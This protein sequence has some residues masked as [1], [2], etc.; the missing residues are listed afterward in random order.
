MQKIPIGQIPLIVDIETGDTV[1]RPVYWTGVRKDFFSP[2]ENFYEKYSPEEIEHR[3][4]VKFPCTRQELPNDDLW[5]ITYNKG[6]R[7]IHQ[8]FLPGYFEVRDYREWI[9]K[10]QKFIFPIRIEF[11][12][13]LLY[14]EEI[15][16]PE[17]LIKAIQE[18]LAVIV[19]ES[20]WE[21]RNLGDWLYNPL[22]RFKSQYSIPDEQIFLCGSQAGDR[23]KISC[24]VP[25]RET[26]YFQEF[27]W[28]VQRRPITDPG[29][30]EKLQKW[31]TEFLS[32]TG[33]DKFTKTF[34]AEIGRSTYE[35]LFLFGDLHEE[36][37]EKSY[38]SFRNHYD[39]DI[40]TIKRDLIALRSHMSLHNTGWYD[41]VADFL[42]T[43][44]F[45]KRYEL[46]LDQ[47]EYPD[48]F[49]LESDKQF[50]KQSFVAIVPE[51]NFFNNQNAFITEKTYKPILSAKPFIVFACSGYL[52]ELH[53]DGFQTFSKYWDES[54][55]D[56]V[57]PYLRMIKLRNTMKTVSEFSEQT[58]QEIYRDMRPTLIH[59][60]QKVI[61]TESVHKTLEWYRKL[62]GT[63]TK[64]FLI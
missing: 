61:S 51:T 13:A 37:L 42:S 25:F 27:C 21:T 16:L 20:P 31:F 3:Y 4:G 35:R 12:T 62:T 57:D 36:F 10:Q 50:R 53:K 28:N 58:M 44:D 8:E 26:K 38:F 11:D 32:E 56:E 14:F 7:L 15:K 30:Q 6:V 29:V 17:D 18:K 46:D 9:Q 24:S 63:T 33:T 45:T 43:Y 40:Q 19:I 41:N 23:V 55:D 49:S 48:W 60:F 2:G 47:T 52:R 54:Y 59:N 5:K 1:W 34:L 22:F 39:A 64:Q